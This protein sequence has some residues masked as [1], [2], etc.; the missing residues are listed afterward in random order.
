MSMV[1]LAI[2]M[3][4]FFVLEDGSSMIPK[5]NKAEAFKDATKVE[6]FIAGNCNG[7]S[8]FSVAAFLS[9]SLAAASFFSSAGGVSFFS[10]S[11]ESR[12]PSAKIRRSFT[13]KSVFTSFFSFSLA[14]TTSPKCCLPEVKIPCGLTGDYNILS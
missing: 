14:Y 6:K 13:T 8:F 7:G 4:L 9:G 5:C 12:F 10:F 1:C 2:G 11:F 3:L